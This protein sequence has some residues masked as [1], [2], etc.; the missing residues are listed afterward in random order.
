MHRGHIALAVPIFGSYAIAQYEAARQDAAVDVLSLE[1][2]RR[3]AGT[4]GPATTLSPT[5]DP[6]R[7]LPNA[8]EDED[9]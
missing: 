1:E 6:R 4:F 7:T 9:Q 2:M 8:S 3:N 5:P